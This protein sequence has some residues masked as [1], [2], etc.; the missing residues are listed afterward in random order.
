MEPAETVNEQLGEYHYRLVTYVQDT[1]QAINIHEG[2]TRRNSIFGVTDTYM[3][4]LRH[5]RKTET[6][7]PM[8]QG[9]RNEV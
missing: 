1:D 5:L 4:Q 8:N 2:N 6:F 3:S 9:L 7:L